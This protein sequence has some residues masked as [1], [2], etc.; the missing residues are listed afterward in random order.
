LGG[1]HPTDGSDSTGGLTAATQVVVHMRAGPRTKM[2]VTEYD[3]PRR[4]VW[5]GRSLG[6]TT[7]FEHKLEEIGEGCTR[8]WFLAWMSGPLAGPGGSIFER[9]MRR[10]L[11]S[12]LPKLKGEIEAGD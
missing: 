5:E 1:A 3:A 9:V 10:Y 7:L 12:A 8:I 11:A 6:V 4:W 2:T